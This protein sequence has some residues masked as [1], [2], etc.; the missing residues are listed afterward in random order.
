MAEKATTEK[1]SATAVKEEIL[2]QIQGSEGTSPDH[3]EKSV[4]KALTGGSREDVDWSIEDNQAGYYLWVK[5]FDQMLAELI[6]LEYL[7][8]ETDSATGRRTLFPG[9]KEP[10]DQI[11]HWAPGHQG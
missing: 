1:D 2:K 11:S 3:L 5:S 4:F 7:R 8:L 6:D 10:D 9:E